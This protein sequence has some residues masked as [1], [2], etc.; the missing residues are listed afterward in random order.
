M[1]QFGFGTYRISEHNQAHID[2]LIEAI[3]GGI[4]LIDTSTNYFD[5]G[6]ERAIAKVL[7]RFDESVR[8]SVEIVSKFGYIQ[9]SLLHEYHDKNSNLQNLLAD[10]VEYSPECFHSISKEF[11][12]HQLSQSLKRLQRDWLH[13]YLIHNPEYFILDAINKGVSKDE[14]LDEM[15][16]RVA[17][18]RDKLEEAILQIPDTKTYVDKK[19]RLP[20]TVIA[21]FRGIEGEAMLWDLNVNYIY[22]AT[23]SSCSSERLEGSEVLEALGEDPEIAHTGII[24]SLSRFTT[25]EEID[26]VIEKLPKIV[27]RL[28]NISMTYAK[29]K[30]N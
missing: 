11:V 17:K 12:H 26:Y 16:S 30:P 23:G 13:C 10:V 3:K 21:S 24:F 15:N 19:Y 5:G 4:T 1:P 14:Y 25:E 2:A 18:L 27:K 9:G 22:A 28:R 7:S 20:N 29:V 6:A 8:E